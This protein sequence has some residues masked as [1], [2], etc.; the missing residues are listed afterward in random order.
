MS[1]SKRIALKLVWMMTLVAL[2][3]LFGQVRHEFIYQ[4]F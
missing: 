3:V 4:A 2:L 1:A